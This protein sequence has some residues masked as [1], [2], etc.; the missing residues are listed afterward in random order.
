M[1]PRLKRP[2]KPIADALPMRAIARHLYSGRHAE[3]P[4]VLCIDIEPDDR[5]VDR[6]NPDRW[7]GL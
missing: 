4:V 1:N 2:L 5:A 7:I 3:I 6:R